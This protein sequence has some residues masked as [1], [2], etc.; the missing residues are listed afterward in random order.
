M[1]KT[2]VVLT[3]GSVEFLHSVLNSEKSTS[4]KTMRRLNQAFRCLEPVRDAQRKEGEAIR[5][6][7]LSEQT[8]KDQ[9]GNDVKKMIIPADK[10]DAYRKET[11]ELLKGTATVEFDRESLSTCKTVVEGVFRRPE[12]AAAG[13][14][15]GEEQLAHLEEVLTAL[16][17]ALGID[18]ETVDV[19]MPVQEAKA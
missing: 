8:I 19:E 2:Q 10:A 12:F 9:H 15:A 11:A 14:M 13:G 18:P 7:Y 4:V 3:K 17:N 16:C 5:D 6:K 1:E